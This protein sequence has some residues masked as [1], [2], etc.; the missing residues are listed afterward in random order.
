MRESLPTCEQQAG[1][2]VWNPEG[3]YPG[4]IIIG[5]GQADRVGGTQHTCAHEMSPSQ[6]RLTKNT[7]SLGAKHSDYSNPGDLEMTFLGCGCGR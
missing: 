2:E 7:N 6:I 4:V 5:G 3:L 1:G